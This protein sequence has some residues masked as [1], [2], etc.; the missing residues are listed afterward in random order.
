[1]SRRVLVADDDPELLDIVATE[2]AEDGWVVTRA[3]NGAELVRELTRGGPW[4][5]IVTDISMPWMNGL[6][7]AR[8]ARSSGL[9]TP[10]LVITALKAGQLDAQ[11]ASL[12]R[13]TALLR[14]PFELDELRAAARSLLRA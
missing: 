11:V 3:S 9:T 2:L 4:D 13:D 1:M 14:K 10:L 8:V 7:V 12:G 5:L 6:E